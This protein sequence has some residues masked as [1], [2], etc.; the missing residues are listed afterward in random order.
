[1]WELRR[2]KMS[3]VWRYA[4]RMLGRFVQCPWSNRWLRTVG[5]GYKFDV[6]RTTERTSGTAGL[7]RCPGI[8]VRKPRKSD[9]GADL[10]RRSGLAGVL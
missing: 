6:R 3:W 9:D 10:W 1:M 4:R 8:S 5:S 2:G 7:S